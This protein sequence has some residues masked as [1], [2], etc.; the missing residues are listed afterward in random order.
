MTLH[1]PGPQ[2]G[3]TD[4][5]GGHWPELA[6][7]AAVSLS[8]SAQESSPIGSLLLDIFILFA[9]VQVD[10]MF[11][12]SLVAALNSLGNRSWTEM[13]KGNGITD[14]WLAQQLRPYGVKPKSLR[15]GDTVL[16]GYLYEDFRRYI[17]RSE[18]DALLAE[19]AEASPEQVQPPPVTNSKPPQNGFDPVP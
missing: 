16:K 2:R 3:T 14:L 6:R 9:N 7:Q 11:T 8:A 17:P 5:A 12:C 10:R 1:G 13:R 18:M 15:I 4:I 19:N